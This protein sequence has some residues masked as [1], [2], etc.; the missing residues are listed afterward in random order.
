MRVVE[1]VRSKICSVLEY[2]FL[3][4][5]TEKPAC[6][7]DDA[8]KMCFFTRLYYIFNVEETVYK[9]FNH[10]TPG[11]S[12][13]SARLWVDE[14][15]LGG[16]S[17]YGWSWPTPTHLITKWKSFFFIFSWRSLP[18]MEMKIFSVLDVVFILNFVL[19]E[20]RVYIVRIYVWRLALIYIY[21][22]GMVFTY[23]RELN[24]FYENL[25]ISWNNLLYRG[26][27][28]HELWVCTKFMRVHNLG[29]CIT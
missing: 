28:G 9:F 14:R 6:K 17:R 13:H 18:G 10:S 11:F 3:V 8:G 12:F 21:E 26:K 16:L 7:R 4:Y 22:F 15:G 1:C 5:S 23:R 20:F 24:E 29:C 27:S 25:Q 2:N 19:R